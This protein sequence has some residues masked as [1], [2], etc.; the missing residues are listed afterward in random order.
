MNSILKFTKG[1]IL[2]KDVSDVSVGIL[3]TLSDAY[4]YFCQVRDNIFKGFRS[5]E[6]T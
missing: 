6:R 3:C 5:I 4:L 1:I 2:Y